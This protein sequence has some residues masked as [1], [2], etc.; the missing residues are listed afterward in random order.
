MLTIQTSDHVPDSTYFTTSDTEPTLSGDTLTILNGKGSRRSSWGAPETTSTV[1]LHDDDLVAVHIGYHHKHR[2]GQYWRY[3]RQVDGTWQQVAW[4]QLD[5]ATR[6][7]VLDAATTKAPRWANVP[8][9]LRSQHKAPTAT[10]RAA[11]KLVRVHDDGTMRSVYDGETVYEIGKRLA[12]RAVADHQG[13][14]YAYPSEAG[15]RAALRDSTLWAPSLHRQTMRLALLEVELSG[16]IL[17][18]D[19]DGAWLPVDD[20]YGTPAKLAAT[21]LR[22]VHVVEMFDYQPAREVVNA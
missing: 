6:Q 3:Y 2:G 11:Y 12:E 5:D 1:V 10:T 18:Y 8:G 17:E 22:P 13:G 21:Y 20:V 7:R 4:L 19:A 16:T 15:L 9:K 14:Y